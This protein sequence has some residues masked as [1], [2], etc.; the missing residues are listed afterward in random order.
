[1]NNISFDNVYLLFLIIPLV[2][3]TAVPFALAIR[4]ENVNGHNVASLVIHIL[5]A[6]LVSFAIAGTMVTTVITETE[7]YVVADVSYSA[8]RNLDT[9]DSYIQNVRSSLPPT[10]GWE[11]W[12]SVK[13]TSFFPTSEKT[14]SA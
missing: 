1:M 14:L 3:L 2:A 10:R 5:I 8:N 11:W 6:V 9:V 12:H 13:I 7:V 4:R